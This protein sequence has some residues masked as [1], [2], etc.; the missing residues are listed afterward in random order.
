MIAADKAGLAVTD[1]GYPT[2]GFKFMPEDLLTQA[3]GH[4]LV[5]GAGGD[6]GCVGAGVA[7]HLGVFRFRGGICVGD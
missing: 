4:L 1:R 2:A 3:L 7:R 6:G 5:E